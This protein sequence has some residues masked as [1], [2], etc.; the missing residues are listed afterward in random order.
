MVV[1]CAVVCMC[2]GGS[3]GGKNVSSSASRFCGGMRCED[4]GEFSKH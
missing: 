2:V 3:S 1:D 4:F